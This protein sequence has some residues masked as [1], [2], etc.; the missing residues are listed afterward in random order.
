VI[1]LSDTTPLNYLILIGRVNLLTDLFGEISIPPAVRDEL[2]HVS[3]P[4]MV[5]DWI[6]H[7][8]SCL[9]VR[10]RFAID[11]ELRLGAGETQAISLALDLRADVL[12]MDDRVARRAAEQR[13]LAVAGAVNVLE[14]S[15]RRNLVDLRAAVADLRKTNFHISERI[16]AEAMRADARRQQR[17]D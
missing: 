17:D 8:P 5:R 11:P 1:V 13:G 7:P 3:S 12:L 15:A 2:N 9:V 6:Q 10:D 4:R 14:A 16:L